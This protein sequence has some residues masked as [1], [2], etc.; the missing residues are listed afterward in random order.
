MPFI[1]VCLGVSL[2]RYHASQPSIATRL[3]LTLSDASIR[4]NRIRDWGEMVGPACA[5]ATLPLSALPLPHFSPSRGLF[6]RILFF[7]L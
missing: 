1:V 4:T 7:S 3:K 5:V 6:L 2:P